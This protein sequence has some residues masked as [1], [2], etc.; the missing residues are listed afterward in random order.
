MGIQQGLFIYLC[1]IIEKYLFLG[2]SPVFFHGNPPQKFKVKRTFFFFF[3]KISAL[4]K[5]VLS[6]KK[7]NI[8]PVPRLSTL[9]PTE[10]QAS[11]DDQQLPHL[12][13]I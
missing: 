12:G 3:I 9:V 11:A 2:D 1:L 5:M 6:I 13:L 4:A 7:W 8:S 10:Q